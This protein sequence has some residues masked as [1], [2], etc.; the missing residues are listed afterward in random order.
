MGIPRATITKPRRYGIQ[1]DYVIIA[2]LIGVARILPRMINEHNQYSAVALPV[3]R[4]VQ[5]H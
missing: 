1:N 5:H 2:A 4:V 3:S